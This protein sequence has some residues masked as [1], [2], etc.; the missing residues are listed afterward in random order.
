MT[1]LKL[2]ILNLTRRKLP[3]YIALISIAISVACGG[4][5]LRIYLLS[6]SRFSTI[7]QIGDAV[8][9]AKASDTDI[10]LNSLNLEGNYPD[11][12]PY[13]LFESLKKEEGWGTN[14]ETPYKLKIRSIIPF[15]YFAKYKNYRAIGTDES[16]FTGSNLKISEG[17]WCNNINEI[18][19][20]KKI[21]ESENL[22]INNEIEIQSWVNNS[23]NSTKNS[24]MFKVKVTGICNNSNSAY[25]YAIFSNLYTADSVF[26]SVNGGNS[27]WGTKVLNYF[28]V[29][30]D[31]NEYGQLSELINKKTVAQIIFAKDE[32]NKL[33]Q[34]TNTGKKLGI[35]IILMIL[36]LG[37]LCVAAMMIT[38]FEA[39]T[40][41]LAVLRAIGYSRK[42]IASWLL[43]E[44]L[45]LG[46]TASIIGATID[47]LG[48]PI[49]RSL[50]GNS[51][52]ESLF[53]SSPVYL[54]YPI[55]IIAILSTIS[56]VWIPLIKIYKQDIH[57]SLKGI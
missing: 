43:W 44:G 25:D 3:S 24:K 51:L 15:L 9:G 48:F 5:L 35:F 41:Q 54:S 23:E 27:N 55:W 13:V 46:I 47:F 21:A 2:A 7:A 31:R 56:A 36:I 49:L 20:G 16:M 10:L 12:I 29:Y 45:I 52:P 8:I 19:I 57:L 50:L 11:F 39:M 32:I 6:S 1:P 26:K 22:K 30:I 42:E 37:G 40:F 34:L 18:V 17:N 38:R 33:E 53:I 4:L 14:N 28:L